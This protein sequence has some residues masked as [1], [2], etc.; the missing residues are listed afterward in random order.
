MSAQP[1]RL[2]L[3]CRALENAQRV[4]GRLRRH[5]QDLAQKTPGEAQGGE[6]MRNAATAAERLAQLFEA[7]RSAAA[8]SHSDP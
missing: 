3:A 7:S 5:E 2:E 1:D 8:P 4:A 6:A